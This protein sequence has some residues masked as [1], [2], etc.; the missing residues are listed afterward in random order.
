MH[1]CEIIGDVKHLLKRITKLVYTFNYMASYDLFHSVP[2]TYLE[3]LGICLWSMISYADDIAVNLEVVC[4]TCEATI[5]DNLMEETG[6]L[7]DVLHDIMEPNGWLVS[8][9]IAIIIT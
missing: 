2:D 9:V 5:A 1:C 8:T 4:F 7:L 6:E 3:I